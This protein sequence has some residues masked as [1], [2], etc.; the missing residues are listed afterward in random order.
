MYEGLEKAFEFLYGR[1][2]GENNQT[3]L[4]N[5]TYAGEGQ[6]P[7]SRKHIIIYSKK[8]LNK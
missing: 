8:V 3:S 5:W 2:G 7:I 1:R 6:I 4:I